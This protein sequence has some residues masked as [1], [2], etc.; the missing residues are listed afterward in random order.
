MITQHRSCRSVTELFE[1]GLVRGQRVPGRADVLVAVRVIDDALRRSDP[2]LQLRTARLATYPI[3]V[4]VDL[5]VQVQTDPA[6]DLHRLRERP[7]RDPLAQGLLADAPV[8]RDLRGRDQSDPGVTA[9]GSCPAA[10]METVE[11]KDTE[12]DEL[13]RKIF[14]VRDAIDSVGGLHQPTNDWKT[15]AGRTHPRARRLAI[16]IVRMRWRGR[17]SAMGAWMIHGT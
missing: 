4:P 2:A 1:L 15:T 16:M 17:G 5:I 7:T 12:M 13:A 3:H 9:P 8:P 6:G 10:T 11:R 14:K